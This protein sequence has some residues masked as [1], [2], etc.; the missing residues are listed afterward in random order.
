MSGVCVYQ[1]AETRLKRHLRLPT[2]FSQSACIGDDEPEGV[3]SRRVRHSDP[4]GSPEQCGQTVGDFPDGHSLSGAQ[5]HRTV[6][7]GFGD[8]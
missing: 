3:W 7:V 4:V 2:Q 1:S 6:H 8:P 5:I